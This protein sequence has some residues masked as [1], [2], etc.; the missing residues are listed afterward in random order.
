MKIVPGGSLQPPSDANDVAAL[1][2]YQGTYGLTDGHRSGAAPDF[3]TA[4]SADPEVNI[5]N[6]PTKNWKHV[7]AAPDRSNRA[8][9]QGGAGAD[10]ATTVRCT[11]IN[12]HFLRNF[13]TD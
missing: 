12:A 13:T 2:I 7:D 9:V 3:A 1:K 10:S 6:D 5:L 8:C 4:M 11:D